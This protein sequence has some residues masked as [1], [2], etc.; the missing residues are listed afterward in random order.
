MKKVWKRERNGKYVRR[1]TLDADDWITL[2]IVV[3]A[4]DYIVLRL[5]IGKV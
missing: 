4:L 2:I 5:I 3:L 1:W